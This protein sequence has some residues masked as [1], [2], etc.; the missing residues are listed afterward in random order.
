MSSSSL[1][2]SLVQN[3]LRW[4][5]IARGGPGKDGR[6]VAECSKKH[7]KSMQYFRLRNYLRERPILKYCKRIALSERG[8]NN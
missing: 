1:R 2:A 4:P 5:H 7:G 3:A 6:V 8:L